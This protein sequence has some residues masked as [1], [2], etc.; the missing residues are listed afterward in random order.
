M[1]TMKRTIWALCGVMWM[2]IPGYS[3]GDV[4]YDEPQK[5]ETSFKEIPNPE[6]A[7]RKRV[8]E[9]DKVLH[10]SKKQYKKIYKLLLKEERDRLEQEI[11]YMSMRT[12]RPLPP[13]GGGYPPAGS[14]H[15]G[16]FREGFKGER[17]PMPP[18]AGDEE[19]AEKEAER[20]KKKTKK[21]RKILT[22]EQYDI[23][24]TLKPEPPVKGKKPSGFHP[25]EDERPSFHP[26]SSETCCE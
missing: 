24:L 8:D 9:L 15:P 17:P 16:G 18:P 7:A 10:L 22:D 25:G 26:D 20:I 19:R 3:A 4:R 23:W 6:K 2:S 11:G 5:Q 13:M 1:R 21:M 12:E 14:G